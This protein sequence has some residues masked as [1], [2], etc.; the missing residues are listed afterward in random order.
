MGLLQGGQQVNED[1]IET[2]RS[3]QSS[4]AACGNLRIA[5][6]LKLAIYE[7]ERLTAERDDARKEVCL[8]QGLDN[9]K[10]S[11]E[12]AKVRGWDCFEKPKTE[13][14][15]AMDRLAQLDEENGLQ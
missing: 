13:Q 4:D 9:G 2:L 12:V 1:I 10:T 11:E 15:K 14:Q 6:G 8:W 3:I 5:M 7:I